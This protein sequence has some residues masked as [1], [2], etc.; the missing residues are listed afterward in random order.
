MAPS[1]QLS[2]QLPKSVTYVPEQPLNL[3]GGIL[4]IK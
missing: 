1:L 3:P 2:H 4:L